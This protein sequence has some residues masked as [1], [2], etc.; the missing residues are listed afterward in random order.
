MRSVARL[1]IAMTAAVALIPLAACGGIRP[2]VS[3]PSSSPRLGTHVSRERVLRH[4]GH[5][6]AD[7][8]I[9]RVAA[10]LSTY[11]AWHS[12]LEDQLSGVT[13][14]PPPVTRIWVVALSGVIHPEFGNGMVAAWEEVVV[15]ARTGDAFED[16]AN[17]A[18]DWPPGFDSIKDLSPT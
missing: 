13:N 17:T 1:T 18:P 7:D 11:G 6:S 10:K 2:A 9:V 3:T 5:G 15:D 12:T 8:H 16:R 4:Y 14:S